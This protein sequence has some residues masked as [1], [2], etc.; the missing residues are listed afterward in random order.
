MTPGA[1]TQAPVHAHA[2]PQQGWREPFPSW[3]PGLP[4]SQPKPPLRFWV[5]TKLFSSL[6]F[7]GASVKGGVFETKDRGAKVKV[8]NFDLSFLNGQ[9]DI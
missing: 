5:L 7:S 9:H 6:G 1:C 3:A 4:H 8:G 2:Q